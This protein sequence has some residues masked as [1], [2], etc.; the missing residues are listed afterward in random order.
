VKK[1]KFYVAIMSHFT[2]SNFY[3]DSDLSTIFLLNDSPEDLLDI[4]NNPFF[5][6]KLF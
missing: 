5:I 1:D 2:I 6:I 4:M 3:L